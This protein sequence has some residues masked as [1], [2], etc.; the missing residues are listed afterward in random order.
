MADKAIFYFQNERSHFHYD[1]SD[2]K[3]ELAHAITVHKAQGSGFG[4]VF[5]V[6]PKKRAILSRELIYTALTDRGK[7]LHL[8][9]RL[10]EFQGAWHSRIARDVQTVMHAI[11][12]CLKMQKRCLSTSP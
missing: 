7:G 9:R 5:L 6:V 10:S 11:R 12:R 1:V 3:I 8:R 4:T 2:E